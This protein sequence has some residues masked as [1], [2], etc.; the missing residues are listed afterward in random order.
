MNPESICTMCGRNLDEADQEQDFH[1]KRWIGYG[2]KYDL[3]IC[4]ARLCC[5]CFDKILDAELPMFK[6][7]PLSE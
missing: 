2:S 6:I 5:D 1:F 7:N 3:N 4:E